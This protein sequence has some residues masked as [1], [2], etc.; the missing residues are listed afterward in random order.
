MAWHPAQ[1]WTSQAP[2]AGYRHFSL[3][4]QGGRGTERWVELAAVLAP[5]HRERVLW[6]DL[7][8]RSLWISGWQSIPQDDADPSDQ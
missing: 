8:D 7:N 3:I 2:V 5:S 1:A 6:S 4:T